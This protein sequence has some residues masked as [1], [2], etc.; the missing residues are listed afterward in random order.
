M[1]KSNRI[2]AI[3]LFEKLRDELDVDMSVFALWLINDYMSGSDAL[4]ALREYCDKEL[5][6]EDEDDIVD[7]DDEDG[8]FFGHM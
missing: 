3:E 7:E 8:D 2:A 5:G 6:L 4:E 1:A